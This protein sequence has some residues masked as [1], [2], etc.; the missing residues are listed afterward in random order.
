MVLL[1]EEGKILRAN[2]AF[3]SI[4][5]VNLETLHAQ[6][7]SL[8]MEEADGLRWEDF[9]KEFTKGKAEDYYFESIFLPQDRRKAWWSLQLA[10]IGHP[11]EKGRPLFFAV[12]QDISLKKIYENKLR[13]ARASADRANRAKSQFLANMSHE[14]RTPIHTIVGMSELLQETAL[15]R[16]QKD[17]VRQVSTASDV[18]LSLVND[19]LD[20]SKI[21]AGRMTISQE[22]FDIHRVLDQS[23]SLL[24]P[25]AA[26][27]GL[28]LVI[29]ED[30]HLPA[31]SVGDP[32]RLRQVLVN[33][34][35]NAVK[36][37]PQGEVLVSARIK[38]ETQDSQTVEIIVKDTGIGVD[39]NQKD[40]L[41]DAFYQV[42]SSH[43]RKFGGSGLGLSISH[44]LVKQQGGEIWIDSQPG[45]GTTVGFTV[46]LKKAGS[47]IWPPYVPDPLWKGKSAL[48][49]DDHPT[50][51][52]IVK[53]YLEEWGFQVT[54]CPLLTGAEGLLKVHPYELIVLDGGLQYP[55]PWS[56]VLQY[57]ARQGNEKIPVLVMAPM[58]HHQD[59]PKG[60]DPFEYHVYKPLRRY[61]FLRS[62]ERAFKAQE[63]NSPGS[64]KPHHP[65]EENTQR[66]KILVAEDHDINRELFSLLLGQ[67]GHEVIMATNGAIAVD[68]NHQQKPDLIFMDLQMPELNGFEATY[69]IRKSGSLVPIVAVTA[70][71]LKGEMERCLQ[72]GMNGCIT[73]PFRSQDLRSAL[74]QVL[75]NPETRNFLQ[76]QKK[77]EDPTSMEIFNWNECLEVFLGKEDLVR[78]LLGKFLTKAEEHLSSIHGSLESKDL[79]KVREE[80]HAIKGSA[81]NLT[82]KILGSAAGELEGAARDGKLLECPLLNEKLNLAYQGFKAKIQEYLE[83]T[84]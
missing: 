12:V 54:D 58:T 61:D 26:A 77:P 72:S 34:I 41:F 19:V 8:H 10:D 74:S 49:V 28:E 69:K 62:L 1:S 24:A 56:W 22:E 40:Q 80:A 60:Q 32:N 6:E 71:A 83:K 17:F 23:L 65:Q 79:K 3:K 81:Y 4:L 38:A 82:A 39:P 63:E 37:T 59:R 52:G 36:F 43:T 9:F 15:S 30:S 73:K 55:D 66:L 33:L 75:N 46:K 16:D 13:E 51:R 21:E 2:G 31:L 45:Q 57:H 5:G 48:V 42:D 35:S 27:R 68:M 50:A 76:S 78:K 20:F 14:I 64:Q 7:L 67:M 18:L 70:S 29:W 84:A 25:S 11:D 47:E 44:K 53:T